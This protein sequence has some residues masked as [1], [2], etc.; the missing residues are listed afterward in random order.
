MKRT[1]GAAMALLAM[2]VVLPGGANAQSSTDPQDLGV[3]ITLTDECT[4]S[5]IQDVAFGSHGN[6]ASAVTATGS[7]DVYCTSGLPYEIA[8]DAG[9]GNGATVAV[10]LMTGPNSATVAYS[11]FKD[12][13]HQELWGDDLVEQ[14]TKAGTGTGAAQ[15]HTIYGRVPVQTTPAS[16][17]YSDTVTVVVHY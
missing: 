9:Q 13:Q 8:L 14:T 1:L 17:A 15:T 4:V 6:L 10:R 11:L 12:D 3:S 2:S 16:G 5:N 7:V